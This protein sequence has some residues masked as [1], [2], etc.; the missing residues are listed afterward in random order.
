MPTILGKRWIDLGSDLNWAEYGGM[1]GR[2]CSDDK[3]LWYVL[4][5]ETADSFLWC[6]IYEVRVSGIGDDVRKFAD[7]G[8]DASPV[9]LV[10]AAAEYGQGPVEYLTHIRP[11]SGA[12][13][14]EDPIARH[15]IRMRATAARYALGD[16]IP[17]HGYTWGRAW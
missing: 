12:W 1:W 9:E 6:G 13:A 17:E 2:R 8:S 15:G 10:A 16:F 4:R 14:D 7:L 11:E 3:D 5:Y